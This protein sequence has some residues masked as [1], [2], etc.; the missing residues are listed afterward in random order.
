MDV[1]VLKTKVKIVFPE[2]SE[3]FMAIDMLDKLEDADFSERSAEIDLSKVQTFDTSFVNIL[4]S[5]VNSAKD[6]GANYTVK[7]PADEVKNKLKLYGIEL[8]GTA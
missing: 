7:E 1:K 2:E 6:A 5:V 8:G 3:N 4:C